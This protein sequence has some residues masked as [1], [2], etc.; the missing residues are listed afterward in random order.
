MNL[1][2]PVSAR[3]ALPEL[4]LEQA[5]ALL[6]ALELL[7]HALRSVYAPKFIARDDARAAADEHTQR[8]RRRPR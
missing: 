3:I 5:E 2:P 8:T 4:T 7:D 1:D 6:L